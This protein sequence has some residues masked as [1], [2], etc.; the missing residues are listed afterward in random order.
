MGNTIWILHIIEI[1]ITISV[2]T[3]IVILL[4]ILDE[5]GV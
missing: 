5:K 3:N 4:K 2:L 1:R